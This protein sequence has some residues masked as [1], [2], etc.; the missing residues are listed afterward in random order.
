MVRIPCLDRCIK[1]RVIQISYAVTVRIYKKVHF[2]I[3]ICIYSS[4]LYQIRYTIII[5]IFIHSINDTIHVKVPLIINQIAIQIYITCRIW[6]FVVVNHVI[7]VIPHRISTITT[8]TNLIV[9]LNT[10]IIIILIYHVKGSIIV[11]ITTIYTNIRKSGS[12][13]IATIIYSYAIY[14]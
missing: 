6:I 2:T 9:I 8:T 13:Y 5:R 7:I 14:K 10:I 11:H 3:W 4:C 1:I 12:C